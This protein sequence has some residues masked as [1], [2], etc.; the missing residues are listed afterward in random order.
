MTQTRLIIAFDSVYQA[1]ALE[2][3][4][5]D[6]RIIPLPTAI[7]AGCGFAWATSRLDRDY[8]EGYLR[9]NGIAYGRPGRICQYRPV[10]HG[11]AGYLR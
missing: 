5:R 2:E 7:S 10:L 6:G 11:K 9:E 3:I 1:L 4:C 8:W